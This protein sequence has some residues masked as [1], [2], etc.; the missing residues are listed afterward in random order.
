MQLP[1]TAIQDVGRVTLTGVYTDQNGPM[2]D[3]QVIDES[4]FDVL[5][6][7]FIAGNIFPD[8]L[9]KQQVNKETL[10]NHETLSFMEQINA[11]R[12]AYIINE[13]A[14]RKLGFIDPEDAIQ[15]QITWS[16]GAINLQPGP[17]VGVVADYHQ[18]GFAQEIDPTVFIYEP[19]LFQNL[20]VKIE[21]ASPTQ[22]INQLETA[23]N[24]RFSELPFEYTILDH[25]YEQLYAQEQSARNLFSVF[26]MVAMLM[27]ITGLIGVLSFELQRKLKVLAIRKVLGAHFWNLM[28]WISKPYWKMIAGSFL[29]V[30][31]ICY[32]LLQDWISSYAYR[33]TPDFSIWL[34][35]IITVSVLLLVVCG[36]IVRRF[37]M[38]NPAD[39][40]RSE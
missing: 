27:L 25:D 8:H 12:Q 3:V 6:V 4:Y 34:I 38:I 26:T 14:A 16:N 36:F 19:M 35:P 5:E 30:V 21:S 1:S 17:I 7:P 39:V 18:E 15:Q 31:P 11:K 29:V 37:S 22:M 32:F 33:A 2:M 23:W 24:N 20:L 13:S 10:G 9:L 40:L 28:I